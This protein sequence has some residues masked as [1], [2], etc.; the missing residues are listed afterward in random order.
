MIF[1][2]GDAPVGVELFGARGVPI[3][4]VNVCDLEAAVAYR[5]AGPGVDAVVRL[6]A[7][8]VVDPATPHASLAKVVCIDGGLPSSGG[9]RTGEDTDQSPADGVEIGASL[10]PVGSPAAL[11]AS[12]AVHALR[13]T[14]NPRLLPTLLEFAHIP[15]SHFAAAVQAE[16]AMRG[17]ERTPT[18]VG[19]GLV[20]TLRQLR[21]GFGDRPVHVNVQVGSPQI[22]VVEPPMHDLSAGV[23][24]RAQPPS[25][26]SVASPFV[27]SQGPLAPLTPIRLRMLLVRLGTIRL[28]MAGSGKVSMPDLGPSSSSLS[29]R[30]A[31]QEEEDAGG[32]P[33]ARE[34]IEMIDISIRGT[35]IALLPP[36]DPGAA[37]LLASPLSTDAALPEGYPHVIE[38]FMASVCISARLCPELVPP[39]QPLVSVGVNV[40]A[41][42]L[43]VHEGLLATELPPLITSFMHALEPLSALA[44]T[45][46]GGRAGWAL[47]TTRKRLTNFTDDVPDICVHHHL[48]WLALGAGALL[49]IDAAAK[50]HRIKLRSTDRPFIVSGRPDAFVLPMI[51]GAL[52]M[53][54][55]SWCLEVQCESASGANRWLAAIAALQLPPS[56]AARVKPLSLAARAAE[57]TKQQ[58]PR[59]GDMIRLQLALKARVDEV[60]IA[61]IP[62]PEFWPAHGSHRHVLRVRVLGIGAELRLRPLDVRVEASVS[63]LVGDCGDASGTAGSGGAA[64]L[65]PLIAGGMICLSAAEEC[66]LD[67]AYAAMNDA[68][69]AAACNEANTTEG[70]GPPRTT[71]NSN[72]SSS[73]NTSS[74][75]LSGRGREL[76]LVSLILV[77]P[78]S[79]SAVKGAAST[80]ADVVMRELGVHADPE[81]LTRLFA[82]LER[83]PA[84][85][86]Q[87]GDGGEE[88]EEEEEE[89]ETSDEEASDE[90]A[91]HGAMDGELFSEGLMAREAADDVGSL[92][93]ITWPVP[94]SAT[95][96]SRA[97]SYLTSASSASDADPG[98]TPTSVRNSSGGRRSTLRQSTG[99]RRSVL[100]SAVEQTRRATA[101][102][103]EDM[104]LKLG[105]KSPKLDGM[106]VLH[107]TLRLAARVDCLRV[108]VH[109]STPGAWPHIH[110]LPPTLPPT[111]P[112]TEL[113]DLRVAGLSASVVNGALGE[114]DAALRLGSITCAGR[115]D[116]QPSSITRNS[117]SGAVAPSPLLPMIRPMASTQ[118]TPSDARAAEI[119]AEVQAEMTRA[120]AVASAACRYETGD[121]TGSG[122]SASGVP[123]AA[124]LEQTATRLAEEEVDHRTFPRLSA[125]DVSSQTAPT[126]MLQARVCKMAP[127]S[128]PAPYDSTI[129]LHLTPL[130]IV[131]RSEVVGAVLHAL[132]P[133]MPKHV[134]DDV[135]AAASEDV[136]V[137]ASIPREST[138]SKDGS[139][140]GEEEGGADSLPKVRLK[141]LLELPSVSVPRPSAPSCGLMLRLGVIRVSNAAVRPTLLT[142]QRP[143]SGNAGSMPPLVPAGMVPRLV[144]RLNV[145]FMGLFLGSTG[146]GLD[147]AGERSMLTNFDLRV[148]IERS[149]ALRGPAHASLGSGAAA[150]GAGAYG[151]TTLQETQSVCSDIRIHALELDAHYSDLAML[152]L[153]AD[154]VSANL[155]PPAPI[156]DQLDPAGAPDSS[157]SVG[158][159][160]QRASVIPGSHAK[161][162][163]VVAVETKRQRSRTRKR[164]HESGQPHGSSQRSESTTSASE[165]SRSSR[166]SLGVRRSRRKGSMVND[167][168]DAEEGTSAGNA[169]R[170]IHRTS[171]LVN[172]ASYAARR[173]TAIDPP[174]ETGLMLVTSV[175]KVD[176]LRVRV[177]DDSG[178]VATPLLQ[179]SLSR[180]GAGADV[181]LRP[182]MPN[183]VHVRV[184]LELSAGYMNNANAGW[185]PI[186]ESW[187]VRARFIEPYAPMPLPAP[188]H[189]FTQTYVREQAGF[190]LYLRTSPPIP[191]TRSSPRSPPARTRASPSR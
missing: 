72:N 109:S 117:S 91:S 88:E 172:D 1:S 28:H 68:R 140:D 191:C 119:A 138:S 45:D 42:R 135:A 77:Q 59:V 22:V 98:S 169:E 54:L 81:G 178:E 65:V 10:E 102:G 166:S 84:L 34:P 111:L 176:G 151:S 83:L 85:I 120:R 145:R 173:L 76:L 40:S 143:V 154:E 94:D 148:V 71:A 110:A 133:T 174:A 49:Y 141:V 159:R 9:H 23:S 79:P 153:I 139:K 104:W 118:G 92:G 31:A 52:E 16:A 30:A 177:T 144:D 50:V 146:G 181:T 189:A 107:P 113:L 161:P 3:L 66:A 115:P 168:L 106:E 89:E 32:T 70:S 116:E 61:V 137:S 105:E 149:L 12:V 123:G 7:L 37:F 33:S 20:S 4:A 35:C 184:D 180:L 62:P 8:E 156:G 25:D 44:A 114:L 57:L 74:S 78:G 164:S 186:L 152:T 26:G 38:P 60:S 11:E 73:N 112:L 108:L 157:L 96:L 167:G 39:E 179:V 29:T 21:L 67:D 56:G 47:V 121:A 136:G 64:G 36:T 122:A 185:E 41:I 171:T 158:R 14:L 43:G 127:A 82:L 69:A 75:E 53:G 93:G 15:P 126:W 175:L 128:A 182:G 163:L 63:A 51:G 87:L 5:P 17:A 100:G 183:D 125:S 188:F 95:S 2:T 129:A 13:V 6:R 150:A 134:Q 101:K 130:E 90:E 46:V 165:Y 190:T 24:H 147:T 187:P 27:P 97:P 124:Y 18:G 80:E 86:P 160:V 131:A 142:A 132:L 155:T 48:C 19:T 58:R 55:S 170:A 99:S 162:R 103:I